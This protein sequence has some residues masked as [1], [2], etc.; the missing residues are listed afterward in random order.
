MMGYGAY[1]LS[2]ITSNDQNH[3]LGEIANKVA[4]A[5]GVSMATMGLA[6]W[7][8]PWIHTV[9]KTGAY[10]D[11]CNQKMLD[12]AKKVSFLPLIKNVDGDEAYGLAFNY[13]F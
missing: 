8:P 5:A 1:I 4:V 3:P 11:D 12:G 7:I 13:R 9:A 10:V 2:E 6:M